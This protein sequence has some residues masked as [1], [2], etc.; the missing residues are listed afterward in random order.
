MPVEKAIAAGTEIKFT[1][2]NIK[3]PGTTN[4]PIG[5]R[6]KLMDHCENGDENNLCTY[7]SS[8][9]YL[10]YDP[11]PSIPNVYTYQGSMSENPNYVSATNAQHTF[12]GPYTVNNGDYVKIVYYP[13]V[14]VPDICTITSNNGICYSYPHENTI[15]IKANTTQTNSYTFTLGGMTNLYRSQVT[16]RPYQE[17]WDVANGNIR[18]RFNTDYWVN[19]ITTDPTSGEQL[20]MTFTPTLTPNYQLKYGFNNIMRIEVT[21]MMQNE[22]IQMLYVSA[23][24][25]ISF[26]TSYCNATLE[27]TTA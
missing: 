16:E 11:T 2:L 9:K 10:E 7:W 3:N 25:E 19:H 8:T 22:H 24:S 21:H 15:L 14:P 4:Y 18:G 27:S 12:T 23:P 5:I 20:T 17:V 13:Q 1:L 6:V 26:Q